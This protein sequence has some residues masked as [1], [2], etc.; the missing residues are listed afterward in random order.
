MPTHGRGFGQQSDPAGYCM[1]EDST[2]GVLPV[3]FF[4]NRC[5]AGGKSRRVRKCSS[6]PIMS[7]ASALLGYE[8]AQLV[9]TICVVVAN[10]RRF[11]RQATCRFPMHI[12]TVCRTFCLWRAVIITPFKLPTIA[13]TRRHNTFFQQRTNSSAALTVELNADDCGRGDATMMQVAAGARLR[14]N[15]VGAWP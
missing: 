6:S 10:S 9:N 7:D 15:I 14:W 4:K 1:T 3:G 12:P 13:K 2:Y 5:Q 11:S 8:L